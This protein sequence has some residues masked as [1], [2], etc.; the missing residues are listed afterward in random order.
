[1]PQ[2]LLAVEKRVYRVREAEIPVATP[3]R[4]VGVTRRDLWMHPKLLLLK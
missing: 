1:M 2:S 3:S 4:I